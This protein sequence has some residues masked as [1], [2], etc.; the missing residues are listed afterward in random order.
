MAPVRCFNDAS[1]LLDGTFEHLGLFHDYEEDL[2]SQKLP[3][4]R[5]CCSGPS[6]ADVRVRFAV[7]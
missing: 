2:S 6:L 7:N 5:A 4:L 1:R 3:I